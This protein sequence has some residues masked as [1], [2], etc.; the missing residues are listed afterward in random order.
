ML[1]E[2]IKIENGQIHN[3]EWHNQRFNSS[4]KELFELDEIINLKNHITPPTQKGV[5]RCRI[6]YNKDII[7]IEYIPYQTRNLRTFKIIQSDIDYSY[8]YSNRITIEK[9]KAEAL[10]YNEIIIEKD[11]LLTDTSIANIAFYNGTYW[12]TPKKPLLR[13]TMRANLL[14]NNQ[15]IEKDIKVAEL[16]DF[17]HFA[18]MN[19][20]IGFQIQKNIIIESKKEKLCL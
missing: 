14:S 12:V 8:K 1:I 6:L 5:F 9:L 17:S 4:R 7:S 18:L 19:A 13:G 10:P 11:G 3:I 16:K 2:T 15:L 20:M